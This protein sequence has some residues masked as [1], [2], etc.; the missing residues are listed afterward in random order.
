MKYIKNKPKQHETEARLRKINIVDIAVIAVVI[1][2]VLVAI[3]YFTDFSFFGRDGHKQMI[4]YTLEFEN[5][6]ADMAESIKEGD[7][8]H[9]FGGSDDM[10]QVTVVKI[11]P[12]VV[13]VY[14]PETQQMVARE[15]P[16]VDDAR[17]APVTLCITV[18][19][20]ALYKSGNGYTVGGHRISIGLPL[21]ITFDGFSGAGQCTAIYGVD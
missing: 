6:D 2:L 16:A 5:V 1:F 10:G 12:Q 20:D 7:I 21:D 13:Y 4:E 15:L 18:R 19:A 3:E 14:D 11:L 8:A 9:G 17:K